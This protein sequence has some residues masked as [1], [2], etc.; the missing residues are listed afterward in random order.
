MEYG[1][2]RYSTLLFNICKYDKAKGENELS[3]VIFITFEPSLE[4][5]REQLK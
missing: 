5:P 3:V 2:H 4:I 1:H